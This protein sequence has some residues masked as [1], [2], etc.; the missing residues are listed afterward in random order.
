MIYTCEENQNETE[1]MADE[2]SEIRKQL[3]MLSL[4]KSAR[5]SAWT[6]DVPTDWNPGSVINPTTSEPFTEVG[7]W[8]FVAEQLEACV[9][10]S[11]VELT[12]PQGKKAHAFVVQ[13]GDRELYVKLQ[14]GS[15]KVVGRSFHYSKYE[16]RTN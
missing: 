15:G 12:H 3:A 14:L 4:R 7:A 2:H 8:E 11:E 1:R 16:R 9:P 13:L 6:K 5:T 10:L